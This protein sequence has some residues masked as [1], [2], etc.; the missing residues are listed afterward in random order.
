MIRNKL[1]LYRYMGN[2]L[3]D[4]KVSETDAKVFIKSFAKQAYPDNHERREWCIR[5][6]FDFYLKAVKELSVI[7]DKPVGFGTQCGGE[8]HPPKTRKELG[9]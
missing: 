8:Y 1:Y 2:S 3:A 5:N 6:I 7:N 4:A 9:L